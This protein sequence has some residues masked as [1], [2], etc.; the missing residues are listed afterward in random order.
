MTININELSY[1]FDPT[2]KLASNKIVGEQVVVTAV[3]WR[4]FH[5]FLLRNGPFFGTGLKL[6]F[7]ALDNSV[8]ELKM[9]V[10]YYLTHHFHD[11]SLA[12]AQPLFGSISLNDTQLTGVITVES[13]QTIGGIWTIDDAKIAEILAERLRNPRTTTWEQVVDMPVSF[14][15]IDHEWNLVDMVGM[16]EVVASLNGIEA[17]L[18]MSGQQGLA[19]H[20]ANKMNPHGVTKEQVLLGLVRNLA[21]ATAAVAIAGT[22]D[23]Y[24]MTPFSVKA[25]MDAGPNALIQAHINNRLNPHGL[26]AAQINVW[27]IAETTLELNK[28]LGRLEKA[29]DS[30]LFAGRTDVEFKGWVLEGTAANSVRF[31]NYT[32]AE[33]AELI[34]SQI[35][36]ELGAGYTKAEAD[37]KLDLKL[38]KTGIAADTSRFGTRD[39]NAYKAWV[40]EGTAANS[41]LYNGKTQAAYTQEILDQVASTITDTYT[42]P[43]ID[44]KLT[45]KLGTLDTAANT[46]RFG[47]RDENAYK[48]WVLEGSSASTTTFG[49]KTYA[50]AKAD[51]L[52][53]K[54]E[55]SNRFNGLTFPEFQATLDNLYGRAATQV[56]FDAVPAGAG[57][58]WVQFGNFEIPAAGTA[59]EN[60]SD[61]HFLVAGGDIFSAQGSPVLN[62]RVSVRGPAGTPVTVEVTSGSS[63]PG[64]LTF[65]Y[66]IEAGGLSG[67]LW[68]RS[69]KGRNSFAMTSLVPSQAVHIGTRPPVDVEPAGIVYV[70]V[71]GGTYATK[72]ELEQVLDAMTE[73][74]TNLTAALA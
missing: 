44:A 64:N 71:T 49:G 7:K 39:S 62:L 56:V 24:Y 9:G 42:K 51:I 54:A 1:P 73:S 63:L 13:Y 48:A 21:T 15:V 33:Y 43:Q 66:L 47:T 19:E 70:T 74:F 38:D 20:I 3:N 34:K 4:D 16:S 65:G 53:G 11:A 69:P 5:F 50:E 46:A 2:G 35:S 25:A 22:S 41:V 45:A 10:D 30:Q 31:G 28:K 26:T 55:D 12:C 60:D 36:V 59:G 6:T 29:V 40:L 58:S 23:D 68:V 18:R 8:R 14:P 67:T 52:A 57:N 32:T 61:G 37:A 27:T 72:D 17:Q